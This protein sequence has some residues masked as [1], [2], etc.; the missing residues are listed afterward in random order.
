[1]ALIQRAAVYVVL[2][3]EDEH[4]API[5]LMEIVSGLGSL[6]DIDWSL[7]TLAPRL[8]TLH[9][10]LQAKRH[11]VPARGGEHTVVLSADLAGMLAHEAMGHPCE[12]DAVLSGAVT[13]EPARPAR[14]QRADHHG[15]PG[16]PLPGPPRN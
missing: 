2:V 9:G 5:E 7:A 12:A 3:G 13:A 1:V 4:G 14:G 10:H 11:A 8:D 6:A 16:A 15:R